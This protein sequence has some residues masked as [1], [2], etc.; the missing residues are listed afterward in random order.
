MLLYT[1]QRRSDVIRFGKQHVRGKFLS[2]TQHKN[3]NIELPIISE[4][5][6]IIDASPTGDLTFLVTDFGRPFS[7]RL[8]QSLPSMV[9]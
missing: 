7:G 1:G 6:K 8:R 4:L 3:R 5:Q 9:R 2:F